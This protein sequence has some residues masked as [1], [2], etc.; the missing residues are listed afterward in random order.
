MPGLIGILTIGDSRCDTKEL[1]ARMCQIIKHED[2]Y[3]IDT[4]SD[5]S[6]SMGRISLGVLNPE[7]Q[8][9]LNEDKSLCI[10]MEG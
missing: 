5:E 3:K 9:I 4:Y 10:L 8:P 2:W 7:P 6:I 1:L